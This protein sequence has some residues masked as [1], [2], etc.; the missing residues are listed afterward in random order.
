MVA[1]RNQTKLSSNPV[2][3]AGQSGAQHDNT[4]HAADNPEVY[5]MRDNPYRNN[6]KAT[7]PMPGHFSYADYHSEI[8]RHRAARQ[9]GERSAASKASPEDEEGAAAAAQPTS[10]H[11][12]ASKGRTSWRGGDSEADNSPIE[13]LA[14]KKPRT[15]TELCRNLLDA[16]FEPRES[17]STL[18][19]GDGATERVKMKEDLKRLDSHIVPLFHE[20]L[21]RDTLRNVRAIVTASGAVIPEGREELLKGHVVGLLFFTESDRSFAFMRRLHAFHKKHNP[22]FIVVGVSVADKELQDVTRGFGFH[23]LRHR[24]GGATWVERDAG[25]E[26]KLFFPLPRLI[27]VDG[28]T[29]HVISRSGVTDVVAHGDVCMDWWR[30]GV[31]ECSVWD[32]V[33]TWYLSEGY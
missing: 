1:P 3:V 24:D 32:Y 7:A 25:L 16:A 6:W 2:E 33:K 5:G 15:I 18:F 13:F 31:T 9:S 4:I 29:G 19:G 11:G 17:D 23:H 20:D 21:M 14:K 27:V 26:M 22:D 10:H 8:K 28:S 12:E 30:R